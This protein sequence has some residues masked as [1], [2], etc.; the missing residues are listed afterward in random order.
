MAWTSVRLSSTLHESKVQLVCETE[1][2]PEK[3]TNDK[4]SETK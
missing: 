1:K 3:H 4:D 2:N